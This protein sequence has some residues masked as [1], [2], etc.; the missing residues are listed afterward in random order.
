MRSDANSMIYLFVFA[1]NPMRRAEP[2]SA[3]AQDKLFGIAR[4]RRT[5]FTP[6][7]TSS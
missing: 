4:K 6:T 5:G 3:F 7:E 2:R 1:P